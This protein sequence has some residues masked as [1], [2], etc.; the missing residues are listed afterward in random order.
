MNHEQDM[1]TKKSSKNKPRSVALRLLIIAIILLAGLYALRNLLIAPHA[2]TFLERTIETN[3]GLKIAIGRLGGSYFWDLEMK[4]V[5]TVNQRTDSP[6]RDLKLHR[7]KLNYRLWD[8]LWGLQSFLA[9]TSVDIEGAHISIN[10]TGEM[11]LDDDKDAL[12]GVLLPAILPQIRIHNSSIQI[13]GTEYETGFDGISLTTHSAQPGE[14]LL[15]LRVTQWSLHHADLRS[16]AVALEADMSYSNENLIIEKLL[17]DKQLIVKSATIGLEEIPH[18]IPFEMI[19]SVAGGQFD[20]NGRLAANRLNV[21]LSGADID[22]SRIS[23]L[24]VSGTL[25]FSGRLSFKGQLD[26]LLSD[27][28]DIIGDLEVQ[29]FNG[30]IKDAIFQQFVFRFLADGRYLRLEDLRLANNANQLIISQASVPA[31]V[32]YGAELDLILRSLAVDWRLEGTDIPSLLKI[33]AAGFGDH[34]DRIPSHRLILNGRMENG[35]VMIPLGRLDVEGGYILLKA[36]EI[37]LQIGER[38]VKDSPL[39]GELSVDLP[40]AEVLSRIFVLPAMG[41]AIRGEIKVSGTLKTPKG[42]VSISGQALTYRKKT[43]GNFSIRAKADTASVV[44]ESAT[45]ERGQDRATAHGTLRLAEKTFENVEIELF[46]V[47][48]APYFSELP[49]LLVSP[50][51]KAP[52]VRGG[53]TATVRLDGPFAGPIGSLS[54]QARQLSVEGTAFGNADVDLTFSADRIKVT[55]AVFKNLNDRMQ[56]S[57]SIRHRQKQL[58]NVRLQIEISDLSRYKTLWIPALSKL[59]GVLQGR[60]QATGDFMHPDAEADLEIE[61]FGFDDFRLKKGSI[62]LKSTGRQISI[63]S[64]ELTMNRQRLQ[65]AG[66]IQRSVDDTEFKI[67]LQKASISGK[68]PLL[69]LERA[70]TCRLFRNG[71]IIFDD[72]ALAGSAGRVS[73]D[74]VFD[75]DGPSDLR[76]AISGLT[77]DGWFDQ[78]FTDRLRFRDL[79]ASLRVSGQA[80]APFFTVQGTIGNLGGRD[81]PMAFSGRFNVEYGN[82]IFKIHEFAWQGAKGQQVELSGTFPLDPFHSDV[83]I[84]GPIALNGSARIDDAGVLEFIIPWA[85][86]SGGSIQCD[87]NVSGTWKRPSGKLHLAVNNLKRPADIQ[88]LPPGPY[89]GKGDIRIDGDLVTLESLEAYS[90]GWKVQIQGQWHGAPTLANLIGSAAPKATG[91]LNLTGLLNVSDLSWIAREVDGV[92]RLTGRLEAQGTL[93]GP[94]TA[95]AADAVIKLS[96]AEFAPDFDMPSLRG[97]NLEAAVTPEAVNVRSLTGELGGAPFELTGSWQLSAKTDPRT[98]LRLRGENLLLYR[99]E[100]SLLR[101]DTDLTLKGP[102]TRLELAGEVAVTDGRF[103]QNFGVL[104]GFAAAGKSDSGSGFQLFSIQKPPLRD[105][106]FDVR[107][108]ARKPFVVRNNLARGSVRPDLVLKGTGEI[109]LLIGNVYVE[110]TRLYLPA[111]RLQLETGLVRFDKIDPDRPRLDLIGTSTMLGYDITAVI[112]G[113]YDEPVITLSSTPPLPNEDLLMLLL[114][115]Q[116]PKSSSAR[117]D[118]TRQGLNVA[119]FLGRD[120]LTRLSGDDSAEAFE[121]I[122]DRFDVEVGRGITQRGEDTIHSQFR[123]ADDVLVDGDSLYLTGERDYFDYYNGGIKLVFRFQ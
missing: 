116:P 112:E 40:D 15:Q 44:I 103:S 79:S 123:V 9:G 37:S 13:K 24:L 87:F 62:Q 19:L 110:S 71:Q 12:E 64:A 48:L 77:G 106:V 17:V 20:A 109:P 41:G 115:G 5:T 67:R 117:S 7:L 104:E 63:Q 3:F 86:N 6:L 73:I 58:D 65:L 31:E 14:S 91:R 39:K 84:S 46:V 88:P 2:I 60:L 61:N 22:L 68:H 52:S 113:P 42:A 76:M 49:F 92:R 55:S 83:F 101:A 90:S 85:Q 95:P 122:L 56:L 78:I 96:D 72:V 32:V 29:I 51:E 118:A 57:G 93:Q 16:I 80:H 69:A 50:L 107:I 59:S 36:A 54:L 108:K 1:V 89:T 66:D 26:F 25:P 35:R 38:T 21:S 102:L 4:N 121:S 98:D 28:R 105:M 75:P 18:Q 70:A 11:G 100:S 47:D 119:V 27:P 53:L 111:G 33:A 120:L 74:G 43:L 82:Q 23:E 114:T 8:F 81:V 99:S 30:T 94:I 97:L 10:L 45:L 34:A